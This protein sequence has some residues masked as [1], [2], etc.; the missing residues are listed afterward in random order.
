MLEVISATSRPGL[1][2]LPQQPLPN[3]LWGPCVDNGR[4]T[5]GSGPTPTPPAWNLTDLIRREKQTPIVLGHYIVGLFVKE[6]QPTQNSLQKALDFQGL[7]NLG[8][9]LGAESAGHISAGL[10]WA[11]FSRSPREGVSSDMWVLLHVEVFCM[12]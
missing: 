6:G 10:C 8:R 1:E 3:R 5:I 4:S 7:W 12:Q 11:H 2:N 9:E